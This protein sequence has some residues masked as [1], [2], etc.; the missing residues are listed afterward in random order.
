MGPP[1]PFHSPAPEWLFDA[2]VPFLEHQ[3]TSQHTITVPQSEQNNTAE[4][5][6]HWNILI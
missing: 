5:L 1:F 2:I 4:K 3:I 6:E